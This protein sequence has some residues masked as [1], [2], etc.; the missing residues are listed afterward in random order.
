MKTVAYIASQEEHH[1]HISSA[2]ELRTL[3]AEF[4]IEYDE[5]FFE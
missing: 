3:M 1:R 4:G 5:R 2:D